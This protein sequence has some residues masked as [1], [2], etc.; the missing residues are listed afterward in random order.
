MEIYLAYRYFSK[1]K[2]A[3]VIMAFLS[4]KDAMKYKARRN[5]ELININSADYIYIVPCH[6]VK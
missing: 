1:E 4:E 5:T 3:C 6:L 2:D